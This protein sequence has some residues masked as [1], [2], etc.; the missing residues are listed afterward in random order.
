MN[1]GVLVT[2]VWDGVIM[3][4]ETIVFVVLF[5]SYWILM[6]QNPRLMKMV[7]G[8]I[9]DRL[10]WCQRIKNYDIVNQRPKENKPVEDATPYGTE[11]KGFEDDQAS[12]PDIAVQ[13]ARSHTFHIDAFDPPIQHNRERRKSFDL[14]RIDEVEEDDVV[15]VWE[16]PRGGSIFDYFWFFFTWPIKFLLHYTIPN[17]VIYKKW[18]ALSFILCIVWIALVAYVIFWMVVIIGDTFGIPGNFI[19]FP[20]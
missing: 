17:P 19:N 20:N 3:W 15:K 5:I 8:L 12:E 11:N 13:R 16:L 14:T 10:M 2:I 1:I 9:E 6:F 18:F 4:Y 7:K